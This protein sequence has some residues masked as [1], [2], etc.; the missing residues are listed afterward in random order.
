MDVCLG[1]GLGVERGLEML[2]WRTRG[3]TVCE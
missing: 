3:M 2:R 1:C